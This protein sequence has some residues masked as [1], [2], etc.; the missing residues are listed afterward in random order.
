MTSHEHHDISGHWQLHCLFNNLLE[1]TKKENSSTALALCEG[2]G[3]TVDEIY[4]YSAFK[5]VAVTWLNVSV[6]IVR[7]LVMAVGGPFY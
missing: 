7:D 1:L 3:Q 6:S 4:R 5:W 2:I